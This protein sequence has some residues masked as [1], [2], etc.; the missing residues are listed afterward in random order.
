MRAMYYTMALVAALMAGWCFADTD[1][2][3]A[4]VYAASA[5]LWFIAYKLRQKNDEPR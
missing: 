1:Y 3:L 2:V 5:V 4:V